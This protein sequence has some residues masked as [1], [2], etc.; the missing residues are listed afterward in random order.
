[1]TNAEPGSRDLAPRWARIG[2][3]L[4]VVVVGVICGLGITDQAVTGEDRFV[5]SGFSLLVWCAGVLAGIIT[6]FAL[7]R[8]TATRALVVAALVAGIVTF[9]WWQI[10]SQAPTGDDHPE[11][12]IDGNHAA[13]MELALILDGTLPSRWDLS[14]VAS[15]DG[16][17]DWLGRNRGAARITSY[18]NIK[19]H[20]TLAE[21]TTVASHLAATGWEVTMPTHD[22]G[23]QH[24]RRLE[25]TRN[26]YSISVDATFDELTVYRDGRVSDDQ[27]EM[28]LTTPCL[29]T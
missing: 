6:W 13:T 9:T 21:L 15:P 23:S 22:F 20:L 12:L 14:F 7:R 25:S 8:V 5:A 18:I 28:S 26:G 2:A 17:R 10:R 27:N 4:S 24:G 16:C 1:M 3:A 11:H 29:R 19:P